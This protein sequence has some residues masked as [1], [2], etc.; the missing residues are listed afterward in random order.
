MCLRAK[1][2]LFKFFIATYNVYLAIIQILELVNNV[3][4]NSLYFL[5]PQS[6]VSNTITLISTN[7]NF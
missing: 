7:Y 5:I 3:I 6:V 1:L 2:I 4:L